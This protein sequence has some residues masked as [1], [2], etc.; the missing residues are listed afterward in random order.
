VF[1]VGGFAESPYMFNMIQDFAKRL[2]ESL[3]VI[4]P[5]FA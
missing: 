4:K 3:T 2:D 5:Q 1:L